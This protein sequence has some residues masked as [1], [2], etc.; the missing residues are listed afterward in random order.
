[1]VLMGG[2]GHPTDLDACVGDAFDAKTMSNRTMDTIPSSLV[3]DRIGNR[4]HT[5]VV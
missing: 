1:M 2:G 4:L 5:C 3:R